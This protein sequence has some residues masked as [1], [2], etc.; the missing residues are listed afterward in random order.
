MGYAKLNFATSVT[1]AQA[2]Y[3]VIRLVTGAINSAASLSYASTS[4][5]EVVNTLNENWTLQYG[6][7]DPTTTAYVVSS[8]C[9]TNTKTHW[10]RFSCFN[11]T[12]WDTS[13]AF[14]NS[15]NTGFGFSTISAATSVSSVTNSTFYSTGSTTGGG[16]YVVRVDASNTNIYLHWSGKHILLY[17][18]FGLIN[19]TGFIGSF[20][21][22]E[23]SLTQ[24]T[25]TS[26]VLQFNNYYNTSSTFITTTTPGSGTTTAILF[27]GINIHDCS[28]NTTNGV[29]NLGVSGIGTVRLDDFDV[30]VTLGTDGSNS[31][32]LVPYYWTLADRGI[33]IIDISQLSGVYRIGR[34]AGTLEALFTVGSDSYVFLPISTTINTPGTTTAHGAIAVIKK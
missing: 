33:P 2:L 3:D 15:V 28:T 6:T 7:V 1:T 5:S 14:S 29:Y 10:I 32:P 8:P 27:Q 9:V 21:Y 13:T 31:Y 26:P 30:P 4:N 19:T 24:F 22:P 25:N 12:S 20:E 11:G 17:G 18:L 16:R 23:N 34:N